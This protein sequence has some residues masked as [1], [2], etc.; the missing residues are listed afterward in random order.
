M[1]P[2]FLGIHPIHG[3]YGGG[4]IASGL[5]VNRL[6]MRGQLACRFYAHA[7]KR[8]F[9]HDFVRALPNG[10]ASLHRL[11]DIK[12]QQ[13]SDLLG[14]LTALH[15]LGSIKLLRAGAAFVL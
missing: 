7:L 6:P 11:I 14:L 5:T 13:A 1:I 2:S 10:M 4:R 15:L 8:V 9:R 12:Q 3:D